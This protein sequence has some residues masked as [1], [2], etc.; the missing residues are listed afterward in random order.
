[1]FWTS[2]VMNLFLLSTGGPTTVTVSVFLSTFSFWFAWWGVGVAFGS[3]L[4]WAYSP[5]GSQL[6]VGRIFSSVF[7]LD[8]YAFCRM[9]HPGSTQRRLMGKSFLSAKAASVFKSSTLLSEFPLYLLFN[10]LVLL[11]VSLRLWHPTLSVFNGKTGPNNLAHHY[12]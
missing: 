6:R 1:M 5:L 11:S 4:P 8:L 9:K 10:T 7:H 2:Q 12:W 3:P